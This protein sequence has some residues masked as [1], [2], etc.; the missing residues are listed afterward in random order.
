[1]YEVIAVFR[2]PGSAP[3]FKEPTEAFICST[4][5]T[6]P[7][8]TSRDERVKVQQQQPPTFEIFWRR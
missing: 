8:N 1:M 2:P 7:F 5:K 6:Q 3:S 4:S